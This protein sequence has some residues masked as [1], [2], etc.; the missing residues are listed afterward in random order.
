MRQ[1]TEAQLKLAAEWHERASYHGGTQKLTRHN[2]MLFPKVVITEGV[3]DLANRLG[4]Y[5]LL[6]LIATWQ[7]YDGKL[8]GED[9]QVWRLG[10]NEQDNGAV[11][12]CEDGNGR[13]LHRTEME[14]T[15]FPFH[16]LKLHCVKDERG[17][18]TIML[19]SE[20]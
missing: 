19:P 12:L 6:D 1:F 10:L 15:D 14:Y 11:A 8:R 13:E 9:F 16:G 17:G 20:R 18:H 3:E 4:C 5:W 2:P 7:T